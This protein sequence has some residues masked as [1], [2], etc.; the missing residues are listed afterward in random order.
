ME[1]ALSQLGLRLI[2]PQSGEAFDPAAHT[3]AHAGMDDIPAQNAV[4]DR[5]ET[6]GVRKMEDA[7]GPGTVL[8]QAVVHLKRGGA[9]WQA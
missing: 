9:S 2:L 6:P 5:T 7:N 4:I 1:Q 8:V 3:P